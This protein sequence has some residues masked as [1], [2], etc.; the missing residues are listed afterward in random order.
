MGVTHHEY[1]SV[2]PFVGADGTEVIL[3]VLGPGEV[4]GEMSVSDSLGR[5]ARA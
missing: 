4:V 1:S 3:A 5:S 2:R